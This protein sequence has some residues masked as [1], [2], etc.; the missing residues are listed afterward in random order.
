MTLLDQLKKNVSEKN[1]A[2]KHPLLKMDVGRDVR[3]AYFQ[4]IVLAAFVDDNKVDA[5]ERAYLTKMGVALGLPK[6]DVEENINHIAEVMK[7]EQ[8][9]GALA[10]EIAEAVKAPAVAKLFLAEFSLIWSSHAANMETLR[11]WR[12][13]LVGLLGLELSDGWFETLDAAIAD[14]PQRAKAIAKLND[15]DKDTLAYLF[16]EAS[17]QA[18]KERNAAAKEAE[19]AAEKVSQKSALE[20]LKT[21]LVRMVEQRLHTDAAFDKSYIEKLLKHAGI[22]DHLP[23]TVLK[24]LLPEAR[25]AFKDF[26]GDVPRL[27]FER[28]SRDSTVTVSTS[29][30]GALLLA[31]FKLFNQ[32]T[33]KASVYDVF[34]KGTF[35]DNQYDSSGMVSGVSHLKF[36]NA[37]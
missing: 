29:R 16:G 26:L 34:G 8:A 23:T 15:F 33:T 1:V 30:N 13:V 4:G 11:E 5:E 22:V 19:K 28:D 3:D 14:T 7:D 17:G 31:F 2:G 37:P 25:K 21:S 18:M 20:G 36:R 24:L 10:T 6:T 32:L 35:T 9:Q 27:K 12:K